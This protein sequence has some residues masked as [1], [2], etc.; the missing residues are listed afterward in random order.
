[1]KN[2]KKCIFLDIASKKIFSITD[3]NNYKK[4]IIL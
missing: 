4:N 2:N 1:M 3:E